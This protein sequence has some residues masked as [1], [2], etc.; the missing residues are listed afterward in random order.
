MSESKKDQQRGTWYFVVDV[1]KADG[2]RSQMRRRGFATKKA[3]NDALRDV[4]ADVT[5][6]TTWSRP[7]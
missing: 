3:A 4:L 2:T 6:A 1:P 5:R 7:P